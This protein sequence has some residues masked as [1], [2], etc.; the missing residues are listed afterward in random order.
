MASRHILIL[1]E[2]LPVPFDRRVWQEAR[3]L[4][5]AGYRVSVICPQM[6]GYVAPYEELEG[7]RI[8]RHPLAEAKTGGGYLQE[9]VSAVWQQSRLAWRI[10]RTDPFDAIH[11]CNPPD[12]LFLVAL[13]FMALG[14]RFLFDHHDI[15][16]ELFEAKFGCDTWKKRLLHKFVLLAE[17]LT[18]LCSR[19]ASIATNQSYKRIAVSRGGMTADRVFVVRSAPDLSRFVPLPANPVWRKGKRYLVGYL[20]TIGPQEGV[21]YLIQAAAY[22]KQ[23]RR[24]NDIQW[25]VIGAGPKW[26]EV[27]QMAR[28]A[29]LEQDI[30]FTGRIPDA[31]MIEAICTSDVCINTD[32]ATPMNDKSTMNKIIEYM[33]LGRPIVQFELTEGRVSAGFASL[34]A[35]PNDAADLAERVESLLET[36]LLRQQ[37]GEYGRRRVEEKLAWKYSVPILLDAYETLFS[38]NVVR[39]AQELNESDPRPRPPKKAQGEPEPIWKAVEDR[40][41]A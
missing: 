24:G 40:V 6:K 35:R 33:A 7:I 4:R 26:E 17:R 12:I 16:P 19:R 38:G 28:E 23:K 37:M 36:P 5:Q 22:L 27:V 29:G 11:A 1:V 3:V 15:N 20:G 25:L 18:F 14:V 9:Y 39:T 31:Q 30:T 32:L 41:V 34:Y 2:N 13:P 10:W 21:Q 8:Y